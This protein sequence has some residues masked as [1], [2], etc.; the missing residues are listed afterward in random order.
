MQQDILINWSPQETRVAIVENG[1]V[2]ELH[3]ERPLERGLVGNIYLGKVSRVL[4]G[5][6]S[7]FIDIG[8]ERAAFL[9]VADVWQRQENGEAPMFARKDQPLTPIEKQVFEGQSIMVQV[10]KDPIGT[11]G[12]RLSTQI[13]IA[14]R[15]LVFLPQDDHIGISQKIPQNE[16]D[17]LRARLQELVGTKEGG[18]G[19]GFIL[20]TNGEE[21]SDAELADD[22]RY[23]RK[24]WARI[25]DAAQK[26]PVMSVL[27]Q[28]LNLLQRVLRDLVGENTQ[29]IRI[30]SREQF[31]L[32]KS[33]GQEY[34]P[35]AVPKLALYKG[36]RPIF[37]LYNIDEEIARALGRRVDLKSGGYLIVDQTEALTTIDVNTGG[38]VGARN[39]DDTIFKTN[40]EAAHAIARQLRL[41]NLG[42][43]VIV[44]FIDMVREEHQ[45]EVLSEFRRQ[46]ARD[47]VKTMAG[48]FSQLGLVEMTRKRT[49]ESLA[50]M[51]CEPCEACSG[52]GNV[53]TARSICY[54]VLREILREARQFNPHEFRVVA[55]PKVVEMFLDEESQHLASLSDFIG[56]PISLQA[57]TAMAQE[58]YDIVLL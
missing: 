46:L 3:M 52:K 41:R 8:L 31:A 17:A 13:S 57:E 24:T 47:R 10:I 56:K 25:K 11:K 27:H 14:G 50:H 35:A 39:F 58:Q 51:L 32:L 18:G 1:A 4:P 20:R 43:I 55:S 7:A 42:G 29:S 12:A 28:D 45:G 9:H 19:G 15:L 49:R 26:L 36:E 16:R 48:G 21:S 34:M 5:M 40:L 23:L 44:D 38:Y 54:E 30:D 2:Q 53:K 6:Q 37:D 33:F 22:I